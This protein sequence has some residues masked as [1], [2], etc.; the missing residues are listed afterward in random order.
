LALGFSDGILN[1]LILASASLLKHGRGVTVEFAM[2]VGCVAFV[3]A[4]FTMFV[5]EYAEMRSRL[6]RATKQLNL[7]ASGH[8][9]AT[10]L[11]RRAVVEA[12]QA[13]V[14]ASVSSF[15]GATI[16]LAIAG[17]FPSV[18]WIGLVIA[19]VL[20]G[21]LGAALAAGLAGRWPRWV[22]GL[23][24]AGVA[25]AAIGSQLDIT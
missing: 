4:I 23:I 17:I 9:A 7:S 1:A 21:I 6:S 19:I 11:G 16:P 25:V 13:A 8:L 12:A 18:S 2:K 14:I 10:A 22:I 20:L 3:T 15:A 24:V 5:A